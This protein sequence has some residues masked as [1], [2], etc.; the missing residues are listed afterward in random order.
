MF[1][2]NTALAALASALHHASTASVV[3]VTRTV[4]APEMSPKT[5]RR[6]RGS[7]NTRLDANRKKIVDGSRSDCP[8]YRKGIWPAAK[9]ARRATVP[10]I[11]NEEIEAQRR[12]FAF[13]N[14]NASNPAVTREMVDM[15]AA[16]KPRRTR[17]KPAAAPVVA[18]APEAPKPR[19]R[20]KAAPTVSTEG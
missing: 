15:A 12:S 8:T 20:A 16:A 14:A 10:A 4:L 13:G 9:A 18:A 2:R 3:P 11:T 1:M 19:R 5:R 7:T 17:A 6:L